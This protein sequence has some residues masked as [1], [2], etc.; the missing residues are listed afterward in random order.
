MPDDGGHVQGGDEAL[1]LEEVSVRPP[2]L[3]GRSSAEE[4]AAA[5]MRAVARG[6]TDEAEDSASEDENLQEESSVT[7]P[8]RQLLPTCSSAA[9]HQQRL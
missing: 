6:G 2:M 8:A 7:S 3:R 4:Q 1:A 9:T 5:F